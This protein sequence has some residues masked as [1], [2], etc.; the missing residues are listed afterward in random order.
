MLRKIVKQGNN[1]HTIT[2]PSSWIKSNNLTAG[3]SVL[4]FENLNDL[5]IK[6]Q[7]KEHSKTIH[8]NVE[9]F[10]TPEI[11]QN[12]LNLY[13]C[14]YSRL[15]ITHNSPDSIEKVEKELTGY[16]L[17][18]HS[19]TKSVFQNIVEYS[20]VDHNQLD[21]LL[22]KVSYYLKKQLNLLKFHFYSPLSEEEMRSQ[23]KVMD[24]TILYLVRELLNNS[25]FKSNQK[26]LIL[27]LQFESIGDF[28]T[29]IHSAI[30]I[31]NVSHKKAI[32][33]L[34][35]HL[36]IYLTNIVSKHENSCIMDLRN[37]RNSIKQETFVDGLIYSL[38]EQL[39]NFISLTANKHS[40]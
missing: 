13:L 37:F 9:H 38:S 27:L 4:L 12:I 24:K 11:V 40:N 6:T 5:M 23:E 20:N 30:D 31:D 35:E 25:A 2:L 16:F 39:Y 26:E 34:D 36:D 1:A 14:G 17:E 22:I 19:S 7:Y 15:V 21:K 8:I 10:Q 18:S 33:N 32:E 3:D 28:L 29:Q